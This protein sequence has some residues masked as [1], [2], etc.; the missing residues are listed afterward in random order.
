MQLLVANGADRCARVWRHADGAVL[1]WLLQTVGWSPLHHV[2]LL[3]E[4]RA[5]ALLE[6]GA[7]IH[8]P[9][10]QPMGRVSEL[11]AALHID[12]HFVEP[13]PTPLQLAQ[14]L[15]DE[16]EAGGA[17]RLVLDAALAWNMPWTPA[18]HATFSGPA[19]MRACHLYCVGLR[20]SR[21]GPFEG[22]EQAFVDVWIDCV[23]PLVVLRTG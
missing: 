19:R 11:M 16:G 5:R 12:Q 15:Q 17:A 2:A 1:H 20:L 21:S 10:R 3:S 8:L 22:H 4:S 14:Q 18:S 23:M 6:A 7:D 9:A 13:Q